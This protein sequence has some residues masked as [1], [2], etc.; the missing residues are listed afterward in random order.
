MQIRLIRALLDHGRSQAGRSAA[1]ALVLRDTATGFFMT[2]RHALTATGLVVVCL[3]AL[4]FARP[5]LAEHALA[6]VA[7][8]GE[9][10][11]RDPALDAPLA[12]DLLPLPEAAAGTAPT[13]A[14]A[15]KA[16][17]DLMRQ[18]Q[19]VANWIARRYRVA[20][21]ATQLFVTTAYRTARELKLDPLLILSVMAIESRFNPFAESPVGAQGLMQVM[22]RVHK[23]KFEPLGGIEA[24]LNPVANIKVGS[25][26]L[27]EYVTRGGSIEAGLKMY[28]GAALMDSD[29]GYGAKVLAE[30]AHLKNVALGRKVS[31]YASNT[32]R[33]P[34]SPKQQPTTVAGAESGN[35]KS[36]AK[37]EQADP[38]PAPSL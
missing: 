4:L 6:L 34:A 3:G 2:A 19:R 12:A 16:D 23:D 30:Y 36:L 13:A 17:A 20:S 1:L 28:V 18:Q 37:A 32:P 31:I 5:D 14:A 25:R 11:A 29:F 26:I 24:A 7:M 21:D 15:A 33:K 35:A 27:K 8:P 10:E 9:S 22:A 38:D